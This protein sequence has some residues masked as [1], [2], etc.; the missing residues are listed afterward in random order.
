MALPLMPTVK[1]DHIAGQK[2]LHAFKDRLSPG[3]NQQMKVIGHQRPG[4]NQEM[5]LPTQGRQPVNEILSIGIG[6]KDFYPFDPS[7]HHVV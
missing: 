7:A 5:T 1:I 6:S 4:I 3:S 2:P